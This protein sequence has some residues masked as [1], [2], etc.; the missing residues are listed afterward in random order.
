MVEIGSV[1]FAE[2]DPETGQMVYPALE[3]VRLRDCFTGKDEDVYERRQ[4]A[5]LRKGDLIGITSPSAGVKDA[6]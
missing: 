3:L 4:P 6:P 2:R 1:M 5:G